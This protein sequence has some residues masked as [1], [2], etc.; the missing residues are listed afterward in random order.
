MKYNYS[1]FIKEKEL[2]DFLKKH[3]IDDLTKT[4]A[5]SARFDC[6]SDKFK[7]NI[8]L[9]CRRKH[10]DDLMLEKKKYDSLVERSTAL[11]TIPLY[12]NSTPEGIW[13]FYVLNKKYK[14]EEKCLPKTTSWSKEKI[15]KEVTYLHLKDGV[16]LL[17]LLNK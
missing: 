15:K 2:F 9:K 1:T 5:T 8:E 13:A 7:L 14:W 10:Y 6:F 4:K 17:N 12:I 16:E 11:D 3:F